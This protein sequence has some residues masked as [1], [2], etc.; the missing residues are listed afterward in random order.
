MAYRK[1]TLRQ[2]TPEARKFAKLIGNLESI[3]KRLKNYMA[4]VQDLELA[5][6]AEAK[7]E[8]KVN[9]GGKDECVCS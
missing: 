2:M 3:T 5:A 8:A 9:K 1:K 4:T 7:R 6:R